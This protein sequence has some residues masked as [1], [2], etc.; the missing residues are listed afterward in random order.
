M[1]TPGENTSLNHKNET[2]VV[3]FK[4]DYDKRESKR[5]KKCF[6]D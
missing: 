4:I 3:D 2:T 6:C 5:D 1:I